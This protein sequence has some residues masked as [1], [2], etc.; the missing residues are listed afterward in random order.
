MPFY[1]RK[2]VYRKKYVKRGGLAS[3]A[4]G[5]RKNALA[6]VA[7]AVKNIQRKMR[8]HTETIN[9]Q[10]VTA[11]S[12]TPPS[13]IQFALTNFN[14][15]AGIFGATSNDFE[16]NKCIHKSV[17][18]QCR[19]SLNNTLP[20]TDSVSF[21]AFLVKLKDEM[22]SSINYTNGTLNLTPGLHYA[23]L[24]AAS[25]IDA[26]SSTGMVMLNK[27]Y[28]TILKY[29]KFVLT[30][31]GDPLNLSTAQTQF[32]TDMEWYWKI[33]T[34]VTVRNPGG[35]WK[36]L[37]ISPDVSDNY[38]YLLFNNNESVD[39]ENPYLQINAVHT[40]LPIQG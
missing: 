1:P 4:K 40:V 17:A 11:G 20:E 33:K 30:N 38:F 27:K 3:I 15:Y 29:K 13:P 8:T 31:N 35:D 24:G 12:I 6:K 16:G 26:N 34:G 37:V 9:F 22:A 2:R 25:P 39:L 18:L 7:S 14:S 10:Q 5:G 32:G 21:T 36:T 28:F 19:I 23:Q